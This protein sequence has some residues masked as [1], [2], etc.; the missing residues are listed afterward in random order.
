MGN[1]ASKSVKSS[2]KIT[3]N[4][5]CKPS[6]SD[7]TFG[8]QIMQNIRL[9]ESPFISNQNEVANSSILRK[10]MLLDKQT[11]GTISWDEFPL[12][13]SNNKD[14]RIKLKESEINEIKRY[15]SIPETKMK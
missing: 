1:F 15:L 9:K 10:R 3:P 14:N 6:S 8:R 12:I 11:E 13:F 4:P 5:S 2:P 7:E